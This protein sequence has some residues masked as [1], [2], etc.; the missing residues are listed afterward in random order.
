MIYHIGRGG[1]YC[2]LLVCVVFY[3][4]VVFYFLL[5]IFPLTNKQK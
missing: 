5:A 4:Y 2:F 3:L 1:I